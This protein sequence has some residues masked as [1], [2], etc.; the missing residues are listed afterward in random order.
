MILGANVA[1]RLSHIKT[2]L[3][4]EIFHAPKSTK[5]GERGGGQWQR[6]A[7]VTRHV[8]VQRGEN[9][10]VGGS[11]VEPKRYVCVWKNRKKVKRG[12]E[13]SPPALSHSIFVFVF[14]RIFWARA[15]IL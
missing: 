4:K 14:L 5:E 15:V 10:M 9:E 12:Q 6:K 2:H 1:S 3:D 7:K 11:L 8:C 13:G